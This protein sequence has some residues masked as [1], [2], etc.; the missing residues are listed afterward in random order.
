MAEIR[1]YTMNFGP[2]TS[3]PDSFAYFMDQAFGRLRQYAAANVIA[4]GSRGFD[5][6][7]P[8][9]FFTAG[10]RQAQPERF[11]TAGL[12]RCQADGPSRTA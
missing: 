12:R 6:L 10:L 9:G 7:S 2:Q 11:F 4:A 5:K 8:N 1:N 3:E